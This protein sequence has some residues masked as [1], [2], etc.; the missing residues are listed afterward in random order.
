[1][2][3]MSINTDY[4]YYNNSYY[5][6]KNTKMQRSSL[7]S[8]IDSNE[9]KTLDADELSNFVADFNAKTGNNIDLSSIMSAYDSNGDGQLDESEQ[10]VINK[11][12]A[13]EKLMGSGIQN[14]RLRMMD[15]PPPSSPPN[16]DKDGD[17]SWNSDELTQF[18]DMVNEATNGS[19]DLESVLQ[20][21]D[22]DGDGSLSQS[23]QAEM[24]KDM[25]PTPQNSASVSSDY[26]D[27]EKIREKIEEL[28]QLIEEKV[29]KKEEQRAITEDAVAKADAITL[30]FQRRLSQG[31]S[32][33][34]KNFWF[35]NIFAESAQ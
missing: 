16:I 15:G 17:G 19:L 33:Y 30:A 8:L 18:I 34:E 22:S 3:Y 14:R 24:I 32:N 26:E 2:E 31:I 35:E 13:W 6:Q 7:N 12:K 21:Y 28:R 27:D 4:S 20:K 10:E 11:E 29:A 5:T 23:E 1:M 9:D 25:A